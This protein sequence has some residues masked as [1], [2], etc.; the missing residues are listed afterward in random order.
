MKPTMKLSDLCF[1]LE[2]TQT[3]ALEARATKK[4]AKTAIRQ[5]LLDGVPLRKGK[6]SPVCVE[7]VG[8]DCDVKTGQLYQK[9]VCMT[10]ER[11]TCE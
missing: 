8:Y 3:F 1:A 10:S 4:I 5:I 7:G 6:F 9:G 11:L 2:G